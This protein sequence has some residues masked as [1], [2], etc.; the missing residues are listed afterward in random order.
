MNADEDALIM[1]LTGDRA[2]RN[3]AL[4]ILYTRYAHRFTAYLRRKGTPAHDSE[5][6]VQEAFLRLIRK[7][8]SFEPNGR[9]A[10]WIWTV[11]RSAWIDHHRQSRHPI[12]TDSVD[13]LTEPPSCLIHDPCAKFDY[14][15]CV[16]DGLSRFAEDFPEAGQAI[17]WAAVDG[18]KSSDIAKALGRTAG[19]TREF[20]SRARKKLSVYLAPCESA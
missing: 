20:L 3:A 19:A 18:M 13:D 17:F 16:R 10:A 4:R 12:H 7:A 6:L 8:D 14:Q 2:T 15:D 1:D 5:D 9:P 11:A